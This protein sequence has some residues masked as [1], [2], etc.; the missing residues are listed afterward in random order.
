MDEFDKC[1]DQPFFT[2]STDYS[3]SF[4][5]ITNIEGKHDSDVLRA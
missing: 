3:G 2:A 4:E 5:N 1:V